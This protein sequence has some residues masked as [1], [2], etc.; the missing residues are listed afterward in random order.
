MS[1]ITLIE[2]LNASGGRKQQQKKVLQKSNSDYV[3]FVSMFYFQFVPYI[4]DKRYFFHF[5]PYDYVLDKR[6]FTV[7]A[8]CVLHIRYF[9]RYK[10][11]LSSIKFYINILRVLVIQNVSFFL[12]FLFLFIRNFHTVL[13]LSVFQINYNSISVDFNSI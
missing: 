10:S 11:I 9:F 7:S 8:M 1:R 4:L 6:Y 3:T 13:P 5:V 2:G 12:S